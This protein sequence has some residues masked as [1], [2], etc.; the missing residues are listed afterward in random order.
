MNE[1]MVDVV[2]YLYENYLDG[3]SRPPVDQDELETEL[4]RAGFS[5]SEIAQ[6]LTWLDELASRMDT[7]AYPPHTAG[8]MRVYS[9]GEC[10]KLDIEARGLLLFLEQ[11]AILDPPS[12]ELV[13]DR[14]MAIQQ[15]A[16]TVEELKWVVLLVLMSRPGRESAH[17]QMEELIY[18]D[19][20]AQVH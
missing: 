16:V 14:A 19:A 15:T 12:R 10:A 18:S 6:A 4:S 9:P 8:A 13:I 11:S 5:H 3:H 7:A 1:S 20:P 17:G 2:I